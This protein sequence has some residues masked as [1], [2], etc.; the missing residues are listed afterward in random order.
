MHG[1]DQ[2]NFVVPYWLVFLMYYDQMDN[3][4]IVSFPDVYADHLLNVVNCS[5]N[6]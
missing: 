4:L 3:E 5:S 1:V 6:I 2:S